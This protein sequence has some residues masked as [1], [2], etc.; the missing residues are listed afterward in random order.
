MC[1]DAKPRGGGARRPRDDQQN[2]DRPLQMHCPR[3]SIMMGRRGIPGVR[4]RGRQTPHHTME[5]AIE[6]TGRAPRPLRRLRF[7]ACPKEALAALLSLALVFGSFLCTVARIRSSCKP[8]RQAN[9]CSQAGSDSCPPYTRSLEFDE[10]LSWNFASFSG[11]FKH[12]HWHT[13]GFL[14]HLMLF[15]PDTRQEKSQNVKK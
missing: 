14:E 9:Q 12:A 2:L 1:L 15:S 11:I 8:T 13:F 3:W 10:I 7:R 4:V 6:H 5:A